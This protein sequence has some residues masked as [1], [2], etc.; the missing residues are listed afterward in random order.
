MRRVVGVDSGTALAQ[1]GAYAGAAVT[2][3]TMESRR[4]RRRR[5]EGEIE[6]EEEN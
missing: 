4:K 5:G 1:L 3:A 2:A 6:E